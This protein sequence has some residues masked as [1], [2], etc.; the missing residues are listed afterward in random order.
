MRTERIDRCDR[1]C[2]RESPEYRPV[3]KSPSSRG[4]SIEVAVARLNERSSRSRASGAA[5]VAVGTEAITDS[6]PDTRSTQRKDALPVLKTKA[7]R[8]DGS[9]EV[10]RSIEESVASLDH[11]AR[12]TKGT[13]IRLSAECA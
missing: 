7:A 13:L 6:A 4:G 2:P 1:R 9:R 11:A 3:P 10:D 8:Q 5:R 12:F